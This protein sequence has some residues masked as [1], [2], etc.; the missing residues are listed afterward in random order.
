V[1]EPN[2]RIIRKIQLRK[3]SPSVKA[4]P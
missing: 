1:D 4:V 3:I 2:A